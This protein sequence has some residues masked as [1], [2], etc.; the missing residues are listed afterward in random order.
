MSENSYSEIEAFYDKHILP[1]YAINFSVIE[2]TNHGKIGNDTFAHYFRTG[3]TEY[4]LVF[5][6][7]PS[8]QHF[9]AESATFI[10]APDGANGRI[11]YRDS[12]DDYRENITGYFSLYRS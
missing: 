1:Q 7:F 10:P 11:V 5:E 9:V 8:E 12:H 4:I 6:D 2:W 3:D